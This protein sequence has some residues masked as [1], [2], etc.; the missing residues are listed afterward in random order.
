VVFTV[1]RCPPLTVATQ[2]GTD[3]S[4]RHAVVGRRQLP[5]DGCKVASGHLQ[6]R[7]FHSIVDRN[8]K[9]FLPCPKSTSFLSFCL[10]CNTAECSSGPTHAHMIPSTNDSTTLCSLTR[11]IRSPSPHHQT[12]TQAIKSIHTQA[13]DALFSLWSS[14]SRL[15]GVDESPSRAGWR[16]HTLRP[17]QR[18]P[19]GDGGRCKDAVHGRAPLRD[20]TG[21]K[22]EE[23]S[24]YCST[25]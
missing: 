24:L 1:M 12:H 7:E 6:R 17:Q 25:H 15:D 16:G 14:L 20:L 2:D 11:L 10:P 13:D 4:T 19:R 5:L 9:V 22:H 23:G 8:G 18:H 3:V 21:V